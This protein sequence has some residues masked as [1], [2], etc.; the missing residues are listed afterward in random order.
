MIGDHIRAMRGGRWNHGIDCG[1]RTVIHVE[2]NAVPGNRVRRSYRPMFEAGAETVE[3]VVHRER[4]YAPKAVVARAF[5]P[6]RDPAL[7]AM[8]G[9]SEA[10]ACW[11]K[12]GT[13]PER[14]RNHALSVQRKAR[15]NAV[16]PATAQS[17][18]VP[19]RGGEQA[20]RKKPTAAR[21]AT[22]AKKTAVAKARRRKAAPRRSAGPKKAG[23]RPVAKKAA[24]K[25]AKRSRR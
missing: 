9:D 13:L 18:T 8:F 12:A 20:T 1:D 6:I 21:K 10:F 25:S 17:K 5:A 16:R 15:A 11:C 7:A 19:A 24:R 22:A 2:A 14:P 4:V 23:R 3:V